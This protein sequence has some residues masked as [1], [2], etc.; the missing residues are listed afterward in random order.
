MSEI[1]EIEK[2]IWKMNKSDIFQICRKMKCPMGTKRDMIRY[3]MLPLKNKNYKMENICDECAICL[4]MNE[5]NQGKP[6]KTTCGH[7]FHPDCL[8]KWKKTNNTCPICRRRNPTFPFSGKFNNITLREAL[9]EYFTHRSSA[10]KKYG[11]I[12]EW[13]VSKV[14]NMRGLFLDKKYGVFYQDVRSFNGDLSKW[15]VSNVKDMGYMFSGAHSFNGDINTK[16]VTL[17]DGTTYTAWDVSNVKNMSGMFNEA[18]L[19]NRYLNKWDVS[20]VKDMSGMFYNA[21]SFNGDI[22]EWDVSNV[23]EMSAMFGN[24]F[25]F[26]VDINTKVILKENSYIAWD[27][28]NVTNMKWMFKGAQS[29]NQDISAW[30]VSNVENMES[31][32]YDARSFNGV[33]SAWNVNK[34]I[35]MDNM[36]FSTK[37]FDRKNAPWYVGD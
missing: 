31:M 24:A 37:N 4:N 25:S 21:S 3:I 16:K 27:V 1:E 13:N 34:V 17:K 26:N 6:E 30:D 20:N 15:D 5:G 23:N 14:T 9:M 2:K 36:F 11:N 18:F 28:G 29:F 12:S 19:F 33:L 7:C 10:I 35:D 8:E 32:F 22:S